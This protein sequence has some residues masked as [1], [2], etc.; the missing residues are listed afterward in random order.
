[1]SSLVR[2]PRSIRARI[3]LVAVV[4]SAG[5]LGTISLIMT[6][7]MRTQLADNFDEGLAQRADTIAAAIADSEVAVLPV[8]EDLLIQ[9]LG[10]NGRVRLSSTNLAGVSPIVPSS[11]GYT[12]RHVPNRTE[13]FR[14]FTRATRFRGQPAMLVVAIN[15]DDVLDPVRIL[16]QLLTY[17][18]PGVVLVLG[19][20]TFVLTG[21]TLRPVDALRAEMAE[22]SANNLERRVHQP[23]TGD[24]VD[25]LARTMNETL[26]RLEDALRRQQRFVADA[27]H[28]LRGPLT[29]IRTELEITLAHPDAVPPVATVNNVLQETIELQHLV[30]DLLSLARSDAGAS[31]LNRAPLDLDDIVGLEARRLR[32][33]GRIVVDTS[34]VL[35]GHVVG[36]LNQI[37]R[38]VRNLFE[39]AERHASSQVTVTLAEQNGFA[40]LTVIDDG[41]GIDEGERDHIFERFTRLDEARTRDS[42]GT[43]LGLAITRDIIVRHKGNIVLASSPTTTFVVDLPLR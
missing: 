18:V 17:A 23:N 28:E 3:T 1:M 15:Y 29:R 24:E 34:G 7:I 16:A 32:E 20:I 41:R 27:S 6:S 43:G 37:T 5:L 21:R 26:D 39:N 11:A 13:T 35:A 14:T 36:D 25:R 9:V 31:V 19:A 8:E 4:L 10:P 33:R 38:A 22:I 30:E 12:T 40:R 2:R 42:G